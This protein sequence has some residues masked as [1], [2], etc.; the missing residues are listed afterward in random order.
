MRLHARVGGEWRACRIGDEVSVSATKRSP[1]PAAPAAPA[2]RA[3]RVA[4]LA[5]ELNVSTATV[6][7][8]LNGSPAVRPQIARRIIDHARLRGYVPNRIAR[9]LAARSKTFV[10]FLVP[11][12][13]NLA[14][15]IAATT[16]ARLLGAAGYQLILAITGDDPR[17][18]HE[19]AVGLAGAQV[20]GII[21]APSADITEDCRAALAHPSVVEFNRTA[22]L[23]PYGVFCDDRAAFV[24]ATRHLLDLGHTDIA[25]LGTTDAVSNGLWRLDGVRDAHAEAGLAL[26]PERVRLVAP[27]EENGHAAAHELLGARAARPTALLVGS[28]NLS[29]GVARAVRELAVGVPEEVSVVVYG[30][31]KWSGLCDPALTTVAVP[32]REMAQ[33]VADLVL[34]LVTEGQEDAAGPDEPGR[35]WLPAALV[36]RSSTGPPRPRG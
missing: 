4:D 30:D 29:V 3:V 34:G 31:P 8:A 13:Q 24:E 18:E 1:A 28:S 35:R 19:A 22:G 6:S 16:C 33:V 36:V 2:E 12:V 20:A 25:Y 26:D 10:G 21:A 27:T 23:A 11:D 17:R 32:Y 15:S 9:S 5:A 7:R 14:Y